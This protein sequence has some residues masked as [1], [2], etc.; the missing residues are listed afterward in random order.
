[1]SR[2]AETGAECNLSC[3][4]DAPGDAYMNC[5]DEWGV[6]CYVQ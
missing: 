3:F 6:V 4:D 1:M 5:N 2:W